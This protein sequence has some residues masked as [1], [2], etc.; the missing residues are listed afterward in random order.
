MD[1]VACL[2]IFE[3]VLSSGGV[4]AKCQTTDVSKVEGEASVK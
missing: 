2:D 1:R 4:L 3:W